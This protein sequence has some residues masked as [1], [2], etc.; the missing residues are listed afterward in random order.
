MPPR[1]FDHDEARRLH[2]EE[3]LSYSEIARRLG[4]VKSSIRS[5]CDPAARPVRPC[6]YCGKPVRVGK[7]SH[8]DKPRCRACFFL[9]ITTS[10]RPGELRCSKC[11]EWKPDDEFTKNRT[12]V[13]RRGREQRCRLCKKLAAGSVIERVARE[14][15]RT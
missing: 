6:A 3:N 8:K 15:L 10:V 2:F 4:V 14:S 1:K 7:N 11:R 13:S 5:A 9:H 12:C